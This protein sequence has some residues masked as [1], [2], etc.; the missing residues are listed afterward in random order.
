MTTRFNKN[1]AHHNCDSMLQDAWWFINSASFRSV[2]NRENKWSKATAASVN[3][4][5]AKIFDAPFGVVFAFQ[6]LLAIA[7]PLP[8]Q[9]SKSVT[10]FPKAYVDLM[11]TERCKTDYHEGVKYKSLSHIELYTN[12]IQ[13]SWYVLVTYCHRMFDHKK[14]RQGPEKQCYYFLK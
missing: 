1:R 8:T 11:R 12:R 2:W 5:R 4:F 10:K 7:K 6:I 3:L 14:S 9:L 13:G